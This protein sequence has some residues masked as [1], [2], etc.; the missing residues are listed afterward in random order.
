MLVAAP[1]PLQPH[2]I[3]PPLARSTQYPLIAARLQEVDCKVEP[4][5]GPAL[6]SLQQLRERIES[7]EVSGFCL[8]EL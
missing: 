4:G 8:R 3:C 5:V 2:G 7:I 1:V 6:T